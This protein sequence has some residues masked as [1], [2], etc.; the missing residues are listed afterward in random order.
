MLTFAEAWTPCQAS[1]VAEPWPTAA[2]IRALVEGGKPT[3]VYDGIMTG[4]VPGK[5]TGW[6]RPPAT[7]VARDGAPLASDDAYRS[8]VLA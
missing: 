5:D 1:F 8:G 3:G 2:V 7:T 6:G 4:F